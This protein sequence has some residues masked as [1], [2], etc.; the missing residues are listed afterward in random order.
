MV[1]LPVERMIEKLSKERWEGP[2]GTFFTVSA[3]TIRVWARRY[4]RSGIS[5]LMDKERPKQGVSVLT[6]EQ[7]DIVCG[8]KEDVPGRSLERII[9]CASIATM[10]TV[11]SPGVGEMFGLM[12]TETPKRAWKS[13][14]QRLRSRVRM[15]RPFWPFV[16]GAL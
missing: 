14:Y 11:D 10:S 7:Q 15:A 9:R 1:R 5:G 8:L 6:K 3:E 16:A 13:P 12:S 4:R 2:D